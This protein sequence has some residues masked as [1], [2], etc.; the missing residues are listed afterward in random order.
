MYDVAAISGATISVRSMKG[1][2]SDILETVGI[3]RSNNII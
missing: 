2:V 3:L 1:A